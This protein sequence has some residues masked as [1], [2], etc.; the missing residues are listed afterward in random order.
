MIAPW[1]GFFLYGWGWAVYF[2]RT[3]DYF[4]N[5]VFINTA[6]YQSPILS[7]ALI[8]NLIP[9]FILL[10]MGRYRAANG[11][12]GATFLYAPIVIYLNFSA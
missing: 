10:Q 9:F 1:I 12:L 4:I 6:R 3:I 5:D 11:V 2:R 8:T 7:I